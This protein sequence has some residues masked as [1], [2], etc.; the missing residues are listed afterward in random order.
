MSKFVTNWGEQPEMRIYSA[1][2]ALRG[3]I[4]RWRIARPESHS[5]EAGPTA[6]NDG[7]GCPLSKGDR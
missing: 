6:C 1:S 4:R 7:W 3:E 5:D 2:G